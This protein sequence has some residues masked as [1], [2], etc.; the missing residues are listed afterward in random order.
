MTGRFVSLLPQS[1]VRLRRRR[2]P[3]ALILGV[4][5]RLIAH[6]CPFPQARV[7]A[8]TK[9][10]ASSAQAAWARSTAP[11]T[12]SCNR[13]VAI[14]VLPESLAQDPAALARFEREAQAVAA[15]SHPN[16]LA[17]HDF[18]TEGRTVYAVTELLEGDTL[19]ARMGEHALPVRKAID[20]GVHIVRGIAAAHERG[21]IHRDLKPENIF[22]TKDGVVKI[23]DFGLAKAT[24][25]LAG[26]TADAGETRIADTAVGTVMGTVGYMSPEQVRG[27]PLDHRTDI[28]SFGA[29]FYEMLTGRRAF[30]GDSHVETMN[31]ILKEDPPEF[32]EINPNLPG[33]L[34]RIV[35]RCL[36][37]QP[38]DRFH[39]AHDLA[40]SLEALSGTSNATQRRRS[41][42]RDR[43]AAADGGCRSQRSRPPCSP[44]A[45][46][47][48]SPAGCCRRRSRGRRRSS[49]A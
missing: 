36:E 38:A 18:A 32:A 12:R 27:Q 24:G 1:H 14:K 49:T 34:D 25:P 7:S 45:P 15:L 10:S 47:R 21:I 8:P 6:P 4:R 30:R 33:S 41:G 37:K 23:L 17:I 43:R 29:V 22:I 39:S 9:S 26:A 40:I 28:F 46:P 13:D 44:S 31:A 20:F 2:D 3:Q 5:D 42:G 48:S 35:R 16:I 19:R 11:A